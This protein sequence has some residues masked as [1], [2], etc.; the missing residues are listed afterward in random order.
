M[1][2]LFDD[3]LAELDADFTEMG[4]LVSEVIQKS[5]NAFIERDAT[6]AQSIIDH[7][8]DINEREIALEKKT[9]EMIALYQPVTTDLREIVTILKA[10]S[11]L[12]RA[13]D[14]ARNIAHS[15]IKMG[16]K[17][18]VPELEQLMAEMGQMTT[19]MVQDVLAAYVNKDDHE[20]RSL[21]D[22]DRQLDHLNH[23][24]RNLSYRAMSQ[25]A[26]FE[27]GASI[28][29]NVAQDLSRIG[30]YVTNVCEWIIYLRSGKIVELNSASEGT[31]N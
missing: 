17:Q 14:H 15:T 18:K 16:E 1:R 30:D 10:V 6:T 31:E 2:R 13:G 24:V 20:A 29:L 3:E 23:Q 21:A 12:E 7:D 26:T 22:V 28:Y 9:F 5:V 4:M 11:D 25:D 19:K 27:T 8:H